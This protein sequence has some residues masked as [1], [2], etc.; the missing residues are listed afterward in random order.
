MFAVAGNMVIALQRV[1][2][3]KFCVDELAIGKYKILHPKEETK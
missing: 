1:S 3:S 2:F